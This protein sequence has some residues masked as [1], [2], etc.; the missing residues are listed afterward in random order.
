MPET[1]NDESAGFD[2]SSVKALAFKSGKLLLLRHFLGFAINFSCGIVLARLLGPEILGLYFISYTFFIIL[3]QFID[4][5]ISTHLIRLPYSP[6]SAD[7][8]TAF[9]IQQFLAL[10]SVVAVIV[11]IGPFAAKWYGR[12]ELFFLIISAGIGAYFNSWQSTPLSQLE[13]KMEYHKVGAIE[14]AEIAVF[15]A[16]A[17]IGSAIGMGILGLALGNVLRGLV[18]AF[19]AVF[20]T[21]LWPAF[22]RDKK[23]AYSLAHETLP[24]VGSNLILWF[25]MFAPP[26]LV[27]TFAGIK[28]LGIAQLVYSLLGTT[29]FI[30]TIF[31]RV[32]LT[33]LAKFQGN[34]ESFNRAVQQVLHLLFVIY[35]PLTMGVAS[36]SPWWVPFIYGAAWADMDKVMLIAAIPV[37]ASAL[38]LIILS[39]LLS[40]GLAAIVFRQNVV[41]AVI[42]WIVMGLTVAYIG[43]LSVPVAHVAAM[44]AV[45]IFISGYAKHCGHIDYKP[46]AA[47][48]AAGVVAMTF[49][50][51]AVR[52]GNFIIPFLVWPVFAVS[53]FALS[54]SVRRSAAIFFESVRGDLR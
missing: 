1:I 31:Q 28:A 30:A 2:A 24:I 43:A 32:S 3:R 9:A 54:A 47:G 36:F 14:V 23:S 48:F 19:M 44:S 16:A 34:M 7:L 42:Y 13:R 12:G 53:V 15:N 10:I 17:V 8:K 51:L 25:I 38:F 41:H 26:A 45:Y 21:G 35:I 33:S 37:T 29:M 46:L 6:T 27:G 49:S 50:W 11:F 22:S 18:P 20:L 5:G 52:K 4:F 39:A 40:K